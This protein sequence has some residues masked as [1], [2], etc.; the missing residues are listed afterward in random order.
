MRKLLRVKQVAEITGMGVSTIW[1]LA[2]QDKFPK[3][4]KLT[5]GMT[6]WNSEDVEA[7]VNGVLA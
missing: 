5:A 6:V 2:K 3:P 7:W 1:R 4:H